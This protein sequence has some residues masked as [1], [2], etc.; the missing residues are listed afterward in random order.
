M[1]ELEVY[2]AGVR[3]LNKILELDEPTTIFRETPAFSSDLASSH[4]SPA[5]VLPGRARAPKRRCCLPDLA[6]AVLRAQD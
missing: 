6:R 1:I 3:D 5:H 2:A 4:G